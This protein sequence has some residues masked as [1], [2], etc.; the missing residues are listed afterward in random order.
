MECESL[1]NLQLF[2]EL[3][4]ETLQTLCCILQYLGSNIRQ[5]LIYN[6]TVFT[7]SKLL[8]LCVELNCILNWLV[9]TSHMS[10]C[11]TLHDIGWMIPTCRTWRPCLVWGFCVFWWHFLISEQSVSC[12]TNYWS[13][14]CC[15]VLITEHVMLLQ[16]RV[17]KVLPRSLAVP[18]ER[19]VSVIHIGWSYCFDRLKQRREGQNWFNFYLPVR[20]EY[21]CASGC[22]F[23]IT[24]LPSYTVGCPEYSESKLPAAKV[25]FTQGSHC[26]NLANFSSWLLPEQ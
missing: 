13:S 24:A 1:A 25:R 20:G 21:E 18:D 26:I 5:S 14:L 12:H 22:Y 7:Q 10:C 8:Y 19:D 9:I 17:K 4:R 16:A 11:S 23:Q 3:M 2:I 6:R 15:H